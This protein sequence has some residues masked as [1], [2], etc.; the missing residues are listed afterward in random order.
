MVAPSHPHS[1]FPMPPEY[2]QELINLARPV[3]D[4]DLRSTGPQLRALAEQN[5]RILDEA[6]ERIDRALA[7]S[8]Q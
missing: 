8:E 1:R 4:R 6:Q 7:L 5:R 2:Q 3:V